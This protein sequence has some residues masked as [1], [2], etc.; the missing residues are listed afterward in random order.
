M[1]RYY[2]KLF[3]LFIKMNIKSQL[4]YKKAFVIQISGMIL[5]DL[6]FLILWFLLFKNF[7]N[8]FELKGIEFNQV[9]LVWAI[10]SSSFG[11]VHAFMGGFINL[12]NIIIN[13][14][15]DN[16]LLYPAN[17]LFL[18]GLS[19]SD[20]SSWGDLIYGYIIFLIFLPV[21]FISILLFTYFILLASIFFASILII[22]S[23]LTFFIGNSQQI[24][25]TIFNAILSFSTYPEKFFTG[26]IKIILFT[27]VPVGLG[28]YIPVRLITHF[29]IVLFLISTVSIF[30]IFFLAIFFFNKGLK[31]YE[32]SSLIILS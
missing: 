32:S 24:K 1:L 30:A 18:C 27:F 9:V 22:L 28:I 3:F 12:T 10:S 6:A 26:S 13:G 2:L 14:K 8:S 19:L 21:N 31:K 4:E 23:S 29:D 7:K 15:L 17:T 25:E 20:A 11:F 5:N 16:Y